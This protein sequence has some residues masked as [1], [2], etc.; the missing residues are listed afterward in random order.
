MADHEPKQYVV[1]RIQEALAH[2]P[3]VG[4]LDVQVKV[5][6]DKV[7]LNGTVPTPARRD[8][9]STVVVELLPD[10]EVHNEIIVPDHA[11]DPAPEQLT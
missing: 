4:E 3:R 1:G 6:G 2:D 11:E 7:F 8:A 5:A 10:H 9:I